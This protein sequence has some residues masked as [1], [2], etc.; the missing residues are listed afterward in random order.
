M[1]NISIT[2]YYKMLFS[3]V[4]VMRTRLLFLHTVSTHL[5][6]L[7]K[8]YLHFLSTESPHFLHILRLDWYGRVD[9]LAHMLRIQNSSLG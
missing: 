3:F 5:Y 6:V 2:K 8:S 7:H 4:K 1:S 9:E